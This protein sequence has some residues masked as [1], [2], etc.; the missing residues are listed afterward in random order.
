MAIMNML[1]VRHF[2]EDVYE[3]AYELSE[4]LYE[5]IVRANNSPA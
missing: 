1:T 5:E 2:Q 4:E 3:K